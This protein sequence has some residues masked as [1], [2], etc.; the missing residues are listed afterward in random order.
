MT[1]RLRRKHRTTLQSTPRAKV[2]ELSLPVAANR[3]LALCWLVIWTA[4]LAVLVGWLPAARGDAP[5]GGQTTGRRML[6][7][8]SPPPAIVGTDVVSSSARARLAAPRGSRRSDP[9]GH[10]QWGDLGLADTQT[11]EHAKSDSKSAE[12]TLAKSDVKQAQALLPA[13]D[14]LAPAGAG[15]MAKDIVA[16]EPAQPQ[17]A[18]AADVEP[19]QLELPSDEPSS[20]AERVAQ[21]PTGPTVSPFEEAFGQGPQSLEVNCD[22]ERQKLKPINAVTN[23]ITAEPGAFPPECGIGDLPF[24]T[25]DFSPMTYTWIAS[26]ICHKPL[27]FE[28]PRLERYGH[29]LPPVIQPI[30]SAALFWVTVPLLPYKM[31]I[32]PPNECIYVLGYYRPSSCAPMQIPG[33]PLSLRGAVYEGLVVTGFAVVLPP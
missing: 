10:Y 2:L 12:P 3:P 9:L 13:N 26:N 20:P 5:D 1:S 23:K 22:V 33:L 21:R 14:S 6:R 27:Y 17:P 7:R 32:E 15:P 29:A 8:A 18:E 31:G 24:K 28:Q 11:S 16:T 30:F 19:R 4:A 25:R